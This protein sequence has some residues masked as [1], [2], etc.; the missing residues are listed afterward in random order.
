MGNP[1]EIKTYRCSDG[2]VYDNKEMAIAHEKELQDPNYAILKRIEAL[3]GKILGLQAQIDAIRNPFQLNKK[4]EN[5]FIRT[6]YGTGQNLE[7]AVN[8]IKEIL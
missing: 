7:D 5:P 4:D 8:N 3:E 2:K 6:W 1:V